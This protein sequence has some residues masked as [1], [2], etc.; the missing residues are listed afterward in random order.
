MRKTTSM[1]EVSIPTVV[2]LFSESRKIKREDIY[3]RMELCGLIIW[4]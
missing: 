1:E 4:G 3:L 2:F